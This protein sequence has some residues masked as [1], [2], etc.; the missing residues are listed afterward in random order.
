MRLAADFG[1]YNDNSFRDY[2]DYFLTIA[3]RMDVMSRSSFNYNLV[4]MRLHEDL[5]NRAAQQG[6]DPTV[7][8]MFDAGL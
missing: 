3:G 4:F 2:Q 6:I 1:V 7:Y 8:H 5:I